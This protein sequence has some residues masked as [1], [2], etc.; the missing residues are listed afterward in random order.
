[1]LRKPGTASM[2][3]SVQLFGGVYLNAKL[4]KVEIDR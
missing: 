4:H 2:V 1:M 3:A